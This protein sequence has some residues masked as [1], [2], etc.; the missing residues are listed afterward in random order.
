MNLDTYELKVSA[1]DRAASLLIAALV[2][3]GVSVTALVVIWFTNQVFVRHSAV[4]VVLENI[5]GGVDSGLIGE[6]MTI[7][8]P[9]IA[10]LAKEA[11]LPDPHIPETLAAITDAVGMRSA[12]LDNPALT[13]DWDEG[14]GGRST[15]DGR[16]PGKGYGDGEPGIPRAQRWQ[17]TFPEGNTLTEYARQLDYFGIE[18]AA[19]GTGRR[20]EYAT[21]LAHKNPQ[22]RAASGQDEQRL[23]MTWQQGNL[24]DADR[25]LLEKAGVQ[26]DDKIIVQFI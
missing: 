22:H 20:I 16:T 6:S 2:L 8:A 9:D 1:Y 15:G 7:D 19:I 14:G 24:A 17:I 13:D 25:Q 4:P 5:G 18:L 3:L 12:Q 11:E 23:Y 21:D 10:D 26:T